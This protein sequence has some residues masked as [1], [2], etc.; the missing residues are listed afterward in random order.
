M[1]SWILFNR[2]RFSSFYLAEFKHRKQ[3]TDTLTAMRKSAI[4]GCLFV[5][6]GF[7]ATAFP[8]RAGGE[9]LY[10][11]YIERYLPLAR[12]YAAPQG[13]PISI[14]LAQ[15]MC[16]SGAG[17]SELVRLANNHFGIKALSARWQGPKYWKEDDE[18]DPRTHQLIKSPF[19]KYTNAEESFADY[20]RHL[21]TNARYAGLFNLDRTDY[22]HWALGLKA[23]GYATDSSYAYR[24]IRKIE[25]YQLYFYD[26]PA[27]KS[28]VVNQAPPAE[29]RG[30]SLWPA[31]P[32]VPKAFA[33]R[34]APQLDAPAH[35]NLEEVQ[36]PPAAPPPACP[37]P[38]QDLSPRPMKPRF[39]RAE[40]KD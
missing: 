4:V 8:V 18:Y 28:P 19:R 25:E 37:Q 9:L 39:T 12:Q 11:S 27:P 22:T 3:G 10:Q 23:A 21:K 31:A 6:A 5:A 40:L 15:A 17:T 14:C 36:V 16:E 35:P 7:S 2:P 20:A 38:G 1:K 13:I 30:K 29:S 26:L 32:A 24:L 34:A 33:P